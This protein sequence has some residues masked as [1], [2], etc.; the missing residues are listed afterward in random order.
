M[1]PLQHGQTRWRYKVVSRIL[2]LNVQEL[3]D[4]G[5]SGWELVSVIFGRVSCCY[6]FKR[7]QF[8]MNMEK[9]R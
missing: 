3:D 9:I 6:H 7:P 4:L 1:T 2:E 8:D 5:D